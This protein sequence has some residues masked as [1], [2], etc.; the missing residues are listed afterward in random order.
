[1]SPRRSNKQAR[2]NQ[3]DDW[4]QRRRRRRRRRR[5]DQYTRLSRMHSQQ[6]AMRAHPHKLITGFI[7]RA[8]R[9][10]THPMISMSQPFTCMRPLSPTA[11]Q[12][13][14]CLTRSLSL[15]LSN[16]LSLPICSDP[17]PSAS[18]DHTLAPGRA[19]QRC[20]CNTC[21]CRRRPRRAQVIECSSKL[22][23]N[24]DNIFRAYLS[25]A[26]VSLSSAVSVHHC[27]KRA[28]SS[29]AVPLEPVEK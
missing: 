13:S 22:G 1:M 23:T 6:S 3:L 10:R 26:R 24:I 2:P 16:F 21:D 5:R 11:D 4:R 29:R 14:V 19:I 9:N 17:N 8:P 27:R 28:S 12:P 18:C 15:P 20:C 25:L 7:T